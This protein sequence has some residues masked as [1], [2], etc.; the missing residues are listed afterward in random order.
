MIILCT[1]T[2]YVAQVPRVHQA[3]LILQRLFKKKFDKIF[4]HGTDTVP[5]FFYRRGQD[6]RRKEK[7][8]FLIIVSDPESLNPDLDPAK[9]RYPDPERP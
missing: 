8:V 4:G 7:E 9:N 6:L 1:L 3:R 5:T 2:I